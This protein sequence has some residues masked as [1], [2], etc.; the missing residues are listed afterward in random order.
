[1]QPASG[2]RNPS[3]IL[4]DFMESWGKDEGVRS[5]GITLGDQA[6]I[7]PEVMQAALTSGKLPKGFDFRV[8]GEKVDVTPGMP[9]RESAQ[10][11]LNALEESVRLLGSGEIQAVVTAPVR[12]PG[13]TPRAVSTSARSLRRKVP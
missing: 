10:A 1:M 11:G 7:G 12:M 5:I 9:S 6:G 13:P 8:I 3:L 4:V 2:A